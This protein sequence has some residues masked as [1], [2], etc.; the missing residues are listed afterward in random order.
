MPP[1]LGGMF[2]SLCSLSAALLCQDVPDE[3]AGGDTQAVPG[4]SR[5]ES[6][7]ALAL[8]ALGRCCVESGPQSL[9]AAQE[10]RTLTSGDPH[11]QTGLTHVLL[12]SNQQAV[13]WRQAFSPLRPQGNTMPSALAA[14]P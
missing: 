8:G 10:S 6:S 7:A 12:A 3:E 1:F 4:C 9:S 13:S 14:E 5:G 11:S 2:R